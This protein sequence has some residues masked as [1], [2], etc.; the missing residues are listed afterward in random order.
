ML[1]TRDFYLMKVYDVNGKCLGVIND[2]SIDFNGGKIKGFC[3][4]TFSLMKKKN[5]IAVEDIISFEDVLIVKRLI[6]F[7]GLK[8]KEIKYMDIINRSNIMK[9]V[10][11]DLIIDKKDYSI[12]GFIIS[13]GIFDRMFKGKEIILLKSCILCESYILYIGED[14]VRFKTLPHNLGGYVNVEKA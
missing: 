1:K 12:H 3:V 5:Y 6:P 8:F 10:L 9:G 2:L 13:S 11:E 4:S 7:A 14:G